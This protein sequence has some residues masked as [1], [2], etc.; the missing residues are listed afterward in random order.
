MKFNK[1]HCSECQ[2][3]IFF[4]G[5]LFCPWCGNDMSTVDIPT[6]AINRTESS[7]V[8]HPAQGFIEVHLPKPKREKKG[9][10][11]PAS[12]H[13]PAC[14]APLLTPAFRYCMGCGLNLL[15]NVLNTWEDLKAVTSE[16]DDDERLRLDL[17]RGELPRY[18]AWPPLEA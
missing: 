16:L 14:D 5:F 10:Y 4:P 15:E 6:I 18:R 11:D 8:V 17:L 3:P 13:C 1:T 2:G 7:N 9:P 12:R